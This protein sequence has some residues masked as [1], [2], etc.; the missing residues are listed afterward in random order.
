MPVLHSR[1]RDTFGRPA[2]N[3]N[4]FPEPNVPELDRRLLSGLAGVAR[5]LRWVTA[6]FQDE[7]TVSLVL[8]VGA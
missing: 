3:V 4:D 1:Y 6:C 2:K 5:C 8:A 7:R